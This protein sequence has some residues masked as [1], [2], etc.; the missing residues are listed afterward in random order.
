[1]S[2]SALSQ[3]TQD[4]Q[5]K[6]DFNQVHERALSLA[7]LIE[8]RH[9]DLV[10]ILLNYETYEVALDEIS[11]T[12][13]L[14]KHLDEN[15]EYFKIRVGA[16][17]SF[18]PKNQPLYAF[19]CFV[20]IPSLMAHEVH[21]RIPRDMRVFF[22][23]MLDLL[24]I[25]SLF[26]NLH[27]S[28]KE[29]LEFLKERSALQVNPS[30]GESKPVTNAVIFTGTSTHADQLRLVFDK[31]TLF[32]TNGAGHNPIVVGHNAHIP[33]VVE[34]TMSLV[35]YNQGQDCAAPNSILVHKDIYDYFIDLLHRE[36]RKV[37]VG[38]YTDR[39]CRVGPITNIE[40]LKDI[41]SILVDHHEWIDPTTPGIVRTTQ[42]I[43]EPTILCKPLEKGGNYKESFAPLFFIQKYTQDS[44]LSMYFESPYYAPNAMYITLYGDSNY[45]TTL[46]D[47]PIGNKILHK[48]DTFLHNT[49]LHAPGIERGIRP[50][51]GYGQ[52]ASSISINGK[53]IAKPTLP[54]R[55]IYEYLVKPLLENQTRT[56]IQ[57]VDRIPSEIQYKNI[58]KI[59]RL[60]QTKT[61]TNDPTVKMSHLTYFDLGSIKTNQNR[62]VKIDESQLYCLLERPNIVH[63][64]TLEITDLRLIRALQILLER[65][66]ALSLDNFQT[67]LYAIAK[68]PH[69][70]ESINEARQRRFFKNV[71]QLLFG[72]DSG[73][74]LTSFLWEINTQDIDHLLD[75]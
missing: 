1:M 46:I 39:S 75:V 57:K 38:P 71:Y 40:H 73:P 36:L 10:T 28:Q 58:E 64:A 60:Q 29:R 55:D 72:K 32:I 69:A 34:A 63:A 51:G 42:R 3:S 26:A 22:R 56:S 30:T 45:V 31:Q 49:H 27:I 2:T 53:C 18:L 4:V 8:G 23:K 47:R 67:S 12:L 68:D 20:I 59:L 6:L 24:E 7:R 54:Q 62:Y 15:K 9:D 17:T 74:K 50:Y 52:G 35:L 14:L 44:D 5:E 70:T 66:P 25:N 41:G 11:R 48:K 65:R 37:K 33:S 19:S 16:I 61:I 13:D 21:F 43:V